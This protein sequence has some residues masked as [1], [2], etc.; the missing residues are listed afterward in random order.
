MNFFMNDFIEN[1]YKIDFN[2]MNFRDFVILLES[3]EKVKVRLLL[4]L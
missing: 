1:N 4:D 3:L 2:N